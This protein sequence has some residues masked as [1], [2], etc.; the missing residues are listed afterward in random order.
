MT[1]L[2]V[3]KVARF[4]KLARLIRFNR[5]LNKWQ[6]GPSSALCLRLAS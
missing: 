4:L 2:R 1:V 5:M 6:V 3:F